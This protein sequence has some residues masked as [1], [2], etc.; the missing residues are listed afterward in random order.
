MPRLL[1]FK[2]E[3][4][5]RLDGLLVLRTA[6]LVLG[7]GISGKIINFGC[8]DVPLGS[9]SDLEKKTMKETFISASLSNKYNNNIRLTKERIL[10]LKE[11]HPEGKL[12]VQIYC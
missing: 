10:D 7:L 12:V 1:D 5:L 11:L 6:S 2:I 8:K 3:L 9:S 4:L